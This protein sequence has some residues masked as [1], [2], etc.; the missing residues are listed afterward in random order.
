MRPLDPRLLRHAAAARRF[1]LLGAGIALATAVLVMVQAQLLADVIAGG[2]LGGAGPAALTPLLGLV[3]LAVVGR[4][5]LAWAAE[6]AAHRAAADVVRQLRSRIVAHV[7]RLGPRHK[8]LPPTGELATLGARGLD[9]LEGYFGR[10]LPALLIAAVV[11]AVVGVRILTADWVSGLLVGLTVPLIP[12]FAILVGLH[13]ERST[14][15]QW[16]ALAVLG[17][18]FLDLVAGLDVLVAF[19]RA[20]HQTGRLREM[21]EAYRRTTLRTLRVAFLSALVLELV[22]TLSVALVA[23]SIGLRLVDGTLDLAT[24]L[25]VLLLAP[26]VYLPLRAVGAR[27]HDAAAG[28]AAAGAALDLIETSAQPAGRA[29]AP[30][31]SHSALVLRGVR[32]DGRAG[33]VLDGLDLTVRP[34]ETLGV[35]G[36]SGCGKT[37]LI[38]LLAGLRTPDAGAVTVDGVDLT[39]VA[40]PAWMRRVAWV[41]QRPVLLAGTVASNVALADPGASPAAIA[42]AAAAAQLDVDLDT[43]V[44]EDGE[45]LSTGQRRRVALARA[46][47]ADR[48][49]LLLDEPTEGVDARTE[50]EIGDA[51]PVVTAGR[52]TVLVSHRPEVLARCD[53]IVAL[54]GA[55][56]DPTAVPAATLPSGPTAARVTG[57]P[58][59]GTAVP[60]APRP[61]PPAPADA[62]RWVLSVAR[63]Q[64]RRLVAA[65]LLGAAALGCA[66]ALTATSAWLIS[67]AALQPPVLTLM[68]AIVAVRA[69]GLGKG[70]LRYAERLISHD[71]AL[72][73]T[74]GLRVRLWTDLVRVGPAA[75]ARQRRGDLLTRLVADTDAPQ[76]LLVR[77]LLPA[78]SAL[79]VG[80]AAVT[81]LALLL[82]AA[83]LALALG[84][85]VAGVGAPALSAWAARRTERHTAELRAE[86]ATRTVELLDAA[87]DLLVLGAAG[88]RHAAL[89][90]ADTRLG[91]L[92]RRAATATGAGSAVSVLG[93]GLSAVACAALGLAAFAAGALPGPA[94]AVLALTPLALAEVLA[95]LPDA[96]V[97]LLSIVPAVRRMQ[98]LEQLEPPVAGL[99]AAPTP[100]P[101][102]L[103]AHALA[104]RWPGAATDAVRGVDLELGPGR[105]MALTGPSGSGKS[106]VVA[107]L[108]RTLPFSGGTLEADGRDVT[109]L[110]ADAVRAGVAW[111]GSWTH[112]FDSTLRA[113]LGL[114]RPGASDAD[115]VAA[116]RRARL[117]AWFDA[118]PDGLDT[119]VGRHG[120]AVSGG[121]RQ[122]LGIARALLADRPILVLDEPTA[123][124]DA[125]TG[126]ALAA[127]ILAA[128]AD[129]TALIVTHRP[130]QTPGLP[131]V[132]LPA[133][134]PAPATVPV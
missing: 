41:P 75:T 11:P 79:L 86:V 27:F 116:L 80:A 14:A 115:L 64:G 113:N 78:T 67:A 91:R 35:T 47:L 92:R 38:E 59:A 104:V 117:G 13:T 62:L 10:Y 2:F 5:G 52:T 25:L 46:L 85:L 118:L 100:P 103:A 32:V 128:T 125:G 71:A 30:D 82:P 73:V 1:V 88:R 107:A 29:A 24:G 7:L 8:D 65:A 66:V 97:R 95:P 126:A 53:R 94:I 122:R 39:D 56:A 90:A 127:E 129:R 36:P 42:R 134:V 43:P 84:L 76:D 57:H 19:G 112:L 120:G 61:V 48:P 50:A 96:A 111:C 123:H 31:P 26:E 33:P 98:E 28:T 70:V 20:R 34:G 23:V 9:D 21:A 68:V 74:S 72:R 93:V 60:R 81:G 124:L 87:A 44:G 121:E 130:E 133:A 63:G 110:E 6:V 58:A 45:G 17:H 12:L 131:R 108:L 49:L 132:A 22:A 54:P 55:P 83:G 101:H 102:S 18:H 51:L 37:T 3:A 106:T 109:T 69:F 114:A 119:P 16:R 89:D 4:A 77:V 40:T 99:A 105:R 15:R